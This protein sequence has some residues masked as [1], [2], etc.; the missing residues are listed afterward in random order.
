[1]LELEEALQRI[2]AVVPP[3]TSD[4]VALGEA[5]GR[6]LTATVKASIDLPPFDNSAMDGYAVRSSDVCSANLAAPVRLRLIGKIAAGEAFAAAVDPGTCV[7]LFTGSM[8]PRGADA[9]IMQEDSRQTGTDDEILVLE[10][11]K[12]W[13]N[14]RFMGEDVKRGQVVGEAGRILNAARMSLLA[15]TGIEKVE[16]GRRPVVGLVA[17]GAELQQ[18]G[19]PLGP[20]QVFD[21]N[22]VALAALLRQAGALPK[23]FPL[24]EDTI[25]ATRRALED[26]FSQCDAVVTSGGASVGEFDFIKPAFEQSGGVLD[27]WK[28]AIKPG[29]PFVLGRLEHKLLFGLPGNPVS[30]LVTFLLLVRP[31]V[32]RWQGAS[33]VDLPICRGILAEALVNPGERK[34]FV[35]VDMDR[36]GTVRS[37]GVQASHILSSLG[38]ANGLV[39]VAPRS[40]IEPGEPVEVLRWDVLVA[41]FSAV[42][43]SA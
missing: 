18:P 41:Q 34:H 5:F 13:E 24:V 32:L 28:V 43:F 33:E 29:R 14:V 19:N 9:V 39:G 38:R 6:V 40:R 31:A 42:R 11:A 30:A 27:F 10:P 25:G 37:A 12:P 36:A 26:A 15:A 3:P 23:V 4:Q 22:R 8:M 2:L 1:M 16:V 20:G 7:R 35:R 17:S 21:S